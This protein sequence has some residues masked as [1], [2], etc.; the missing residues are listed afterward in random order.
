MLT[1]DNK[2]M[3]HTLSS[4]PCQSLPCHHVHHH[5]HHVLHLA[6]LH[7]LTP[8]TSL[9]GSAPT[10]PRHTTTHLS[11]SS[12]FMFTTTTTSSSASS[13]TS[14][15]LSSSSTVTSWSSSMSHS[16][17]HHIFS[18]TREMSYNKQAL[19]IRSINYV[20]LHTTTKKV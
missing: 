1:R 20:R 3:R 4:C 13:P 17:Y 10:S 19:T 11:S 6:H 12:S 5:I 8:Q 14:G 7:P 2:V 15:P 18:I 16:W 9:H